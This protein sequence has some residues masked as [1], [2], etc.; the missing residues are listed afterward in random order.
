ME[1]DEVTD[2]SDSVH[3]SEIFMSHTINTSVVL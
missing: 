2:I 3:E 1:E